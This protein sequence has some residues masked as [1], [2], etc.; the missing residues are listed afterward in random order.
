MNATPIQ[1]PHCKPE[2]STGRI[3][4]DG[5]SRNANV[6]EY[7]IGCRGSTLTHFSVFFADHQTW[8]VAGYQ[9]SGDTIG[10]RLI[11]LGTCHD[12]EQSGAFRIGDIA[13]GARNDIV[14]PIADSTR[15]Q[16]GWI[17]PGI[18]FC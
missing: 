2:P 1:Y 5:L 7:D 14:V 12:R 9:K 18:W 16:I 3:T 15:G 10:A 17:G 4:N 13:F 8:S 11:H 6:V